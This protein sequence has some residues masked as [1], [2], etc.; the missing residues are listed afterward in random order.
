MPPDKILLLCVLSLGA[1]TALAGDGKPVVVAFGESLEPYVIP[2]RESGI[3]VEIVREALRLQGL[4]LVPMFFSQ[5]RLPR[6]LGNN[7]IDAIATITPDSGV[8]AAYSDVYITY[9]D[10]A[11]TLRSRELPLKNIADLGK[12]SIAA[13]P[14]ASQYLGPD[15]ARMAAANPRYGETGNQVDQN[16][17]LYRNAV[18]V[19]VADQRIFRYMDQRVGNDFHEDAK[20]VSYHDLF[21]HL[22]YRLAFRSATLR[23][24]FNKG[25]AASQAN[26]SYQQILNR[27]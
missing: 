19:V 22:P 18:D 17:L 27:F 7:Q 16:R 20:D 23:D 3:E 24:R 5:K 8:K 11:I 9:E 2:Q 12:Y 4:T 1:T 13:F 15:F 25:L 26:G 14:L 6:M 21:T 10:M